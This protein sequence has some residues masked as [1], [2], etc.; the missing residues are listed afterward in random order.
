MTYS[1]SPTAGIMTVRK[2]D[3]LMYSKQL[4]DSVR[5]FESCPNLLSTYST[6][7]HWQNLNSLYFKI[8]AKMLIYI[9]SFRCLT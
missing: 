5:A 7:L 8:L 3:K 1:M 2:H 9:A 4:K 6:P